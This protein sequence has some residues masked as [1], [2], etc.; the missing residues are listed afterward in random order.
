MPVLNLGTGITIFVREAE[1]HAD[2]PAGPGGVVGGQCLDTEHD[3]DL[4][5]GVEGGEGAHRAEHAAVAPTAGFGGIE[6]EGAQ[7][8]ANGFMDEGW[9]DGAVFVEDRFGFVGWGGCGGGGVGLGGDVA[10]G[11]FGF[12]LCSKWVWTWGGRWSLQG[13]G[14]FLGQFAMI[15]AGCC[16]R[17]A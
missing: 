11:W 8:G 2:A 6:R 5:P 1:V 15:Y 17:A 9:V 4:V 10:H 16:I 7:Q 3:L 14:N 13:V 12:L